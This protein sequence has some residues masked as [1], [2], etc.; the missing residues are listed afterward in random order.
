MV[1]SVTPEWTRLE[2]L[3]RSLPAPGEFTPEDLAGVAEPIRRY[4]NASVAPGTPLATGAR[5][6]MRGHIKLGRWLPF[7][8]RQ[9]LAPCFGTVW[10]ARV[11]G[12]VSGSDRYVE[13]CG[14]MDWKLLGLRRIVHTDGKDVTQS[15]AERAAGESILVPTAL[16]STPGAAWTASAQDRIAVDIDT[17]GHRTRVGHELDPSGRVLSSSFQRW[18]DPDGTGT[19]GRHP[20]GVEV[21]SHATF[22]GITIPCKG[23]AGWHFGTDRWDSGV[24][25]RFEITGYQLFR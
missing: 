22:D 14:G 25:F 16:I 12:V 11:A 3:L 23:R 7:R 2:S 8:A 1:R 19:W 18:G 10:Q 13:G 15:A 24:F 20:F 4:F 9:L 21:T 5:L 6:E 17:D